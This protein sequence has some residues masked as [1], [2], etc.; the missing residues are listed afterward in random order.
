MA[1]AAGVVLAL[2]LTGCGGENDSPGDDPAV[3]SPSTSAP[4]SPA[5]RGTDY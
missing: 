3:R 5:P 4:G 1:L 2:M